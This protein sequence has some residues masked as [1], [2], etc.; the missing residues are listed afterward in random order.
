HRGFSVSLVVLTI[1]FGSYFAGFVIIPQWQ[2]AWLGYTA[3]QAGFSSSFTAI[4][5]LLTAPLVVA[6]MSRVDARA[7]VSAGILWISTMGL[8]RVFWTSD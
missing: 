8:L 7:L 3:T 6:L 1:S 2:Q 5:G 4:A